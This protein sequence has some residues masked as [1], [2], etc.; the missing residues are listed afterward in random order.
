MGRQYYTVNQQLSPSMPDNSGFCP[1]CMASSMGYI[2][3]SC[4][5][6]AGLLVLR[7]QQLAHKQAATVYDCTQL[8]IALCT[9]PAITML[10]GPAA[11]GNG[12]LLSSCFPPSQW[13]MPLLALEDSQA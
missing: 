6:A 2:S 13:A 3:Q 7:Q 5:N 10:Q 4:G 8:H 12:R 9:C 1:S 11:L